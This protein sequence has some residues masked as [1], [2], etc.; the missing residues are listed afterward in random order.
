MYFALTGRPP[1]PGGANKERILRHR[2]D[3]AALV[4][5]RNPDVPA[6]FAEI[7]HRLMAK[8]PEQ[9]Y[10]SVEAVRKELLA[11][12][13]KE[14]SLLAEQAEDSNFRQAV[15][16]IQEADADEDLVPIPERALAGQVASDTYFW[17][18]GSAVGLWLVFMLVVLVMVL[19]R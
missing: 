7:V 5:E 17:I 19:Y 6:R 10:E 15:A 8:K 12:V 2:S 3:E 4:T 13:P 14:D 18:A 9:R 1:F 16:S 11:F